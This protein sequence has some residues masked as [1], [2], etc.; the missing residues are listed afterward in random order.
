MK[1]IVSS[2]KEL[3]EGC[4]RC[5]RE[6]PIEKA[7]L[8]YQDENGNIKVKVDNSKCISCG[9]CLSVCK[10]GARK[11]DDDTMLFFKDLSAG[12]RLS[13]IAAPS[14]RTNIPEYKNL[15]TFLKQKG[16]E[17]IYDVSVGA[18][19]CIWAHL[20]HIK[21]RKNIPVI[22]QP[23]AA[24][25]TYCELYRPQ[26]LK[27]LSP[28]QSPMACTAIY[29]REYQGIDDSIAALS[30][31]IAKANEFE[32]TEQIQYNVTFAKLAE[33]LKE[34]NIKLPSEETEFDHPEGGLGSIFPI[35][36]GF[37]ENIELFLGKSLRIDN[38]EGPQVYT[39]LDAYIT[40]AKKHLPAIFDVLSCKQ[41]CSTGP[42]SIKNKNSFLIQADINK[43][44]QNVLASETQEKYKKLHGMYDKNLDFMKFMR[45]YT[46]IYTETVPVTEKE[47]QKAFKMLEKNTYA[48][49]NFNCGA[50]G[51]NSCRDMA[52]K[53]ALGINLP[54]NCIV[55]SRDNMEYEHQKNITLYKRN[56]EYIELIQK[57]GNYILSSREDEHSQIITESAKD[58]CMM[59][60]TQST[61][62][63]RRSTDE[64]GKK[65]YKKYLGWSEKDEKEL[66]TIY[67]EWLPEWFETLYSGKPINKTK[68]SLS[69][70]EKKIFMDMSDGSI[71]AIPVLI[72][73][74]FWGFLAIH[75]KDEHLFDEEEVAVI[76]ATGLLVVSSIIEKEL[77]RS[78]VSAREQA[79]S[80]TY[81]KSNFLSSMSHEMR[82]PMNAIIGM[83]KI[84]GNTNDLKKL[85]YCLDTI[86]T[87][88]SH[89]LQLINDILDMSKIEAGKFELDNSLFNI[90]KMLMKV[91]NII[92]EKAEQKKHSLS[93]SIGKDMVMRY[94]GD[95][96]RLSQVLSN[97][98]SNA[99]KFTPENGKISLSVDEVKRKGKMSTLRFSIA[100]TGIGMNEEQLNRL[101]NAFEQA[102]NS[103]TRRFGGTGL[104]LAISKN[105]IEKMNGGVKVESTV[106]KGSVFTFEVELERR[107]RRESA[108]ISSGISPSDLKILIVDS[109]EQIRKHFLAIM[110]KFGIPSDTTANGQGAL[111]LIDG[112]YSRIKPYDVI[113]WDY[114][115][116][117]GCLKTIEHLKKRI[118]KNTV[119]IMTSFLEWSKIEPAAKKIGISRFIPKPLF[120]ST[121][122]DA[123]NDVIGKT[124]KNVGITKANKPQMP[125][126]SEISLLLVEDIDINREIFKALL[127]DT[128]INIDTAENGKIAVEMFKK[129]K[130][131][132]D[133]IIMDIQMPEMDGYQATGA[134]RALD[135]RQSKKIPIIAMTAN[136]FKEDI[137]KCLSCGMNDH[138]SKPIDEKALIQKIKKYLKNKINAK[139]VCSPAI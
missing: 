138:L 108:V 54:I 116:P 104:G 87:S 43:S 5:A 128:R 59:L 83:T 72:K 1:K 123:I 17:K 11:Y 24:V 46:P 41:G 114:D 120:P 49:Q 122:L 28:V 94:M 68:A 121:I 77:T 80:G 96:L 40:T 86:G 62:I 51:S 30:P 65:C 20:R 36:G 111:E 117:E 53:I 9:S 56:T 64:K 48:K 92:I 76:I 21:N 58:L 89:L 44:R 107:S 90:E 113:F 102:D 18:D 2:D 129:N 91:F 79:L 37:R 82:T 112:A 6:C 125:D 100:D 23:C 47:I 8:I 73:G 75:G 70:K 14:I 50:C 66:E 93:V 33:Y 84:A 134:I 19:I 78:L 45:K 98:L 135:C 61:C 57:I 137:E 22:T 16:V 99:V 85:K 63:W 88:A 32:A 26:L 10:H 130:N 126:F 71:L 34:Q 74:D 3:C 115:M 31:C 95:E 38:S 52:K 13:V 81:A 131:K 97:I 109:D 119:I 110:D 55:K 124:A 67:P 25:V 29:M 139:K 42:G 105:I 118:D 103:I 127:E 27:Y 60:R 69:K 4:N 132:Y 35:P 101:F 136:A 39:D 15:F 106:G 12:K 133:I 7:N